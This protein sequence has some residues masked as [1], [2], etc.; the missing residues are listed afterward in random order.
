MTTS[1]I[2]NNKYYKNYYSDLYKK[3]IEYYRDYYDD[4]RERLIKQSLQYYYKNRLKIRQ[5]QN[6]YYK[7]YYARNGRLGCKVKHKVPYGEQ[8]PDGLCSSSQVILY[9][10]R[11]E[12]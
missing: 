7:E 1:F 2:V 5:R 12:K 3:N 10:E 11:L 9:L 4:N 6:I 8:A